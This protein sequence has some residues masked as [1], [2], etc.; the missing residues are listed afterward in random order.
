MPFARKIRLQP[1]NCGLLPTQ[2]NICHWV[3]LGR[4]ACTLFIDAGHC[5]ICRTW[6]GLCLCVRH[7]RELCKNGR[8][9]QDAVWGVESCGPQEGSRSPWEGELLRGHV[10]VM[11]IWI[12]LYNERH[13][14]NAFKYG[15]MYHTVEL[16]WF[17]QFQ[18]QHCLWSTSACCPKPQA[19]L[20]PIDSTA[21]AAVT[22]GKCCVVFNAW[23][24]SC[25]VTVELLTRWVQKRDSV[26][27]QCSCPSVTVIQ[28]LK[29]PFWCPD[30]RVATG[31][32]RIPHWGRTKFE[33]YICSLLW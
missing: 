10:L 11:C 32:G 29:N 22:A 8:T 7:N 5:Y 4:I 3:L 6:V 2:W 28:G 26:W 14:C 16:G 20:R 30:G 27:V 15:T 18:Q 25:A 19:L 9:D 13:T 24:L 12:S 21:T 33:F 17:T 1:I 23:E 31:E